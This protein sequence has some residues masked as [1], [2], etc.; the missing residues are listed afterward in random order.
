MP[1]QFLTSKLSS[2]HHYD[3]E[4]CNAWKLWSHPSCVLMLL[5]SCSPVSSDQ[6]KKSENK[7]SIQLK[8]PTQHCWV[9]IVCK[10]GLEYY[11]IPL[12]KCKKG[13]RAIP[14]I[15]RTEKGSVYV[16]LWFNWR[17]LFH[18]VILIVHTSGD[19]SSFLCFPLYHQIT[20][21]RN[22]VFEGDEYFSS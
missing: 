20:I 8:D 17:A 3:D 21:S 18:Q 4:C 1:T 5:L 15:I 7:N 10:V 2:T 19:Y 12:K 16:S 9:G 13:F 22:G 11:F 6:R 14:E